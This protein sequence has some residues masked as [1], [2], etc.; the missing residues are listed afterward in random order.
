MSKV[1]VDVWFKIAQSLDGGRCSKY[2]A[3]NSIWAE[4]HNPHMTQDTLELIR[5]LLDLV[6]IDQRDIKNRNLLEACQRK[7]K[8]L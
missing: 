2:V 1:K 7:C 8:N 6:V 3:L 4:L 5:N